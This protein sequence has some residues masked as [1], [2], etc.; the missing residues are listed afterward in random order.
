[1]QKLTTE[2]EAILDS[3]KAD[4]IAVNYRRIRCDTVGNGTV[5]KF[6]IVT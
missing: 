3:I 4:H 2:A 5:N 1:M 6:K